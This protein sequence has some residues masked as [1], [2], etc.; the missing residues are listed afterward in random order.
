MKEKKKLGLVR[1]FNF[2]QYPSIYLKACWWSKKK[3][4]HIICT[5]NFSIDFREKNLTLSKNGDFYWIKIVRFLFV[6]QEFLWSWVRNFYLLTYLLTCL[7]SKPT[8]AHAFG[9]SRAF[10]RDFFG[11]FSIAISK[12][13][14]RW[15]FKKIR[16]IIFL[17][18][19]RIGRQNFLKTIFDKN[20]EKLK[21]KTNFKV[22]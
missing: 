21:K 4:G 6:Q 10:F 8:I 7:L 5:G 17:A 12:R 18:P 11:S 14:D 20:E 15:I 13:F 16:R 9:R 22:R 3:K 19:R 2:W 1:L